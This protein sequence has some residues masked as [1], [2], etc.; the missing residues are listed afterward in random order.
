[1]T[2]EVNTEQ[3][4]L[5]RR[6]KS[7]DEMKKQLICFGMM[8]VFTLISSALGAVGTTETMYILPIL[9]VMA[10]VQAGFQFYFFMHLKDRDHEM[11]ATFI[12]GGVWAGFLPRAGLMVISWW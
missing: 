5:L 11:P 3:A 7:K 2:N 8:T 1:M 4:E 12:Y 10:I 9:F 6:K